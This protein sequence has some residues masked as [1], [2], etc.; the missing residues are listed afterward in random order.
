M[1]IFTDKQ[2]ERF[3]GRLKYEIVS[4]F[5]HR[6]LMDTGKGEV[7]AKE[8]VKKFMENHEKWYIELK[9]GKAK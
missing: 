1:I 7:N 5:I 2:L 3:I 9:G 8:L 6:F 4:E